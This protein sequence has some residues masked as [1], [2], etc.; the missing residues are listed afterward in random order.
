MLDPITTSKH[1]TCVPVCRPPRPSPLDWLDLHSVLDLPHWRR[2]AAH[3]R[4]AGLQDYL[5]VEKR[6]QLAVKAWWLV[7][8]PSFFEACDHL[9]RHADA[10]GITLLPHPPLADD[11]LA[12]HPGGW[13]FQSSAADLPSPNPLQALTFCRAAPIPPLS[14]TRSSFLA[15]FSSHRDEPVISLGDIFEVPSL[16]RD[17][18]PSLFEGG[19]NG[20]LPAPI[21]PCQL[22]MQPPRSV[23]QAASAFVRNSLG[24]RF[25]A[26]HLRR[27]DF[28]GH[29]SK[30]GR[31][32]WFPLRQLAGCVA[33][34]LSALAVGGHGG[35]H[36]G[37]RDSD[38]RGDSSGGKADE[39]DR[40]G[41]PGSVRFLGELR[42]GAEAQVGEH[43]GM[44]L[45]IATDALPDVSEAAPLTPL[46]TE[47]MMD[48]C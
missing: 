9:S 35:G 24:T 11:Q 7:P 23:R 17:P 36:G 29:C 10:T 32:C 25:A 2:C 8:Q 30:A 46:Q 39:V 41:D 48:T 12:S 37:G 38:G 27:G 6:R 18:L 21:P 43:D 19:P 28:A 14:L 34:R 22:A 47:P 40:G 1:T 3:S 4:V 26:V 13:D 5:R 44:A 15:F 45:F 16:P 20:P 42:G 33:R 31:R